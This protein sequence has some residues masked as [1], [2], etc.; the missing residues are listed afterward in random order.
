VERSLTKVG[1]KRTKQ[2]E[3]CFEKYCWDGKVYEGDVGVVDLSL[4][5]DPGVSFAEWNKTHDFGAGM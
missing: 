3:S 2:C 5:L 4:A 1:L